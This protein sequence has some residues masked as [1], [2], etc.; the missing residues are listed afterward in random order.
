MRIYIIRLLILLSLFLLPSLSH[1]DDIYKLLMDASRGGEYTIPSGED[2][3]NAEKLFEHLFKGILDDETKRLSAMIGFIISELDHSGE[4]L[5][6][7]KEKD[8]KKR[9]RGFFIFRLDDYREFA[10]QIPHAFADIHTREIGLRLFLDARANAV[11]FN[12]VAREYTSD[13]DQKK[14]ADMAHIKESYF[15]AF[16]RAF[17]RTHQSGYMVQ[18]HGFSKQKRITHSARQSDMIISSGKSTVSHI[19]MEIYRCLKDSTNLKVSLYP[20]DVKELG[21][22]TNSTGIILN[23]MGYNGFVHI[24]M[25]MVLRNLLMNN[26]QTFKKLERCIQ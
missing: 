2:L 26:E 23:R 1:A 16:A 11:V 18:L 6:I 5:I 21:G 13:K 14:E 10:I 3:Q 4:K 19:T 25:S 7:L 8:D 9:G 22:K 15:I 20:Y 24:E 12:T 17:A